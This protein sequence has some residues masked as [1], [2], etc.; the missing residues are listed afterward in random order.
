MYGAII[1]EPKDPEAVTWANEYT[2][3]LDDWDSNV[4]AMATRYEPNHNYFLLNVRAFPDV[5]T[6]TLK[7]GE[8]TRIRLINA[9]YSNV[10]AH[11]RTQL[12]GSGDDGK[13]GAFAYE[14]DTL[15]SHRASG[16]TSK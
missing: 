3:I 5:P 6:L 9:A 2:L 10:A 13:I 16:T 11:A 14:K 12:H 8:T 1:I 15:I 4:D 7:V